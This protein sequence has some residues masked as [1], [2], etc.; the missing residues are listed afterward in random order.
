MKVFRFIFKL[1]IIVYTVVF[2]GCVIKPSEENLNMA[3]FGSY[4]SNYEKIIKTYL[5]KTLKDPDSVKYEFTSTP[6]AT[7]FV[8]QYFIDYGWGVC[9]NLNAKNSYGGYTGYKINLFII[10]YS[11][12]VYN[13][14]ENENISSSEI[15]EMCFKINSKPYYTNANME[16]QRTLDYQEKFKKRLDE[17]PN[18]YYTP[19]EW[20]LNLDKHP[21]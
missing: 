4:P 19:E 2:L 1:S 13:Y 7:W 18:K 20:E 10:K 21:D 16:Y 15:N 11:E 3:N 6:W 14:I 5:D 9:A 8:N 12:V 17:M